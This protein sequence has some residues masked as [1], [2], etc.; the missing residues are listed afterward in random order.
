MSIASCGVI[1]S[2]QMGSGI[3]QV[4]AVSG[5]DVILQDISESQLERA[6]AGIQRSLDKLVSKE[7]LSAQDRDGALARIS[8]TTAVDGLAGCDLIIEA[9]TENEA[10]KLQIFEQVDAIAKPGAILATNTS[11]ISITRIAAATSR[12][13]SV[14][15]MHFFNPVPIM[16]LVEIIRGLD[17]SDETYASTRAAAEAMGKTVVVA[18]DAPGFIVNRVLIPMLNEAVTALHEGVASAEDIDT[19]MKLGTNQPMGPLTLMD[20]IGLDTVLA[21][22]EV[23]HTNLGDPRY[24]PCPL[25]RQYVA[26]GRLGRKSGRGFFDY[27]ES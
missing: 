27:R 19:A 3:A 18:Q 23:L 25:L 10:L 16:K 26:A 9:A 2:G 1:G 13:E 20:F 17:T 15:G 21:I 14:V 24:R 22:A 12:P 5:L 6:Q 8:T 11:S 4:A 7:R